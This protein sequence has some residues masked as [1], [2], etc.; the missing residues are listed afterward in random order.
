MEILT[1]QEADKLVKGSTREI[2]FKE[3]INAL[4]I[5]GAIKIKKTEWGRKSEPRQYYYSNMRGTVK[6]FGKGDYWLIVK[7]K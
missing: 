6:V 3:E 4:E 1:A 5:G 7:N 2:L